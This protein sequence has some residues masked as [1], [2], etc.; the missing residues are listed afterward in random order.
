MWSMS[1]R[2]AICIVLLLCLLTGCG[3]KQG[4]TVQLLTEPAAREAAVSLATVERGDVQKNAPGFYNAMA[5]YRRD[6]QIL[7][8]RVAGMT[9]VEFYVNSGDLVEEGQALARFARPADETERARLE[10]AL[11]AAQLGYE[12][13]AAKA[14]GAI[15]EAQAS[16]DALGAGTTAAKVAQLRLERAKAAAQALN[17]SAVRA[18]RAALDT[19]DAQVAGVEL[20]APFAGTVD[21]L[22]RRTD[23]PVAAET[24]FCRLYT[25]DEGFVRAEGVNETAYRV[26]ATVQIQLSGSDFCKGTVLSSPQSY[27]VV[28]A[29]VVIRP[30][31]G[32]D[33]KALVESPVSPAV[34]AVRILL[35]D[36]LRVPKS[37]VRNE[38]GKYYVYLYEDGAAHRRSVQ[39]GLEGVDPATG[40]AYYQIIDGLRD[41]DTVQIN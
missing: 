4:R 16:L 21:Q 26:G 30:E 13:D 23:D 39:V 1:R 14:Q 27:G 28:N 19:Y 25:Q 40:T 24:A 33:L 38:E 3:K 11:Q 34:T 31:A 8:T 22:M 10:R 12:A 15:A 29:A 37:A 35:Q 9:A 36:V 32:A 17:D 7:C 6:E 5:Y 41:G 18:A 2:K 20:T